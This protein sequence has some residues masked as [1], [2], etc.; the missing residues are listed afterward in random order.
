MIVAEVSA[1]AAAQASKEF[2]HMWE[3]KI[4]KFKGGYLADTELIFWSWQVDILSHIQDQELDKKSAIQLIKEQTLENTCH[5]VEFQL[6]F[7]SGEI[8]YQNLLKHLSIAFQGGDDEAKLLTEFYSHGQKV[9]ESEQAFADVLQIL[10][11]KVISKKPDFHINL[12]LI[13]KQRYTSQLYDHSNVLIVKTL[14][15][16]M[17]KCLFMKFRNE[18]ARVLRTH[19]WAATKVSSKA[20]SVSPAEVEPEGEE[21]LSKSQSKQDQKISAQSSQ[22]KDIRM[23]L[24]HAITEN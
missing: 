8:V 23:K 20:M 16:Q 3:P 5:E 18:L 1:A 19:K 7:C 9:K 15:M 21:V 17:L 12:D 10:T 13:L 22:I 11:R 24:D 6:D 2:Q 4:T 14:L